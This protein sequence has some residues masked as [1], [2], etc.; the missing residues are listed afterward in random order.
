MFAWNLPH[1]FY[2][3]LIEKASRVLNLASCYA[4]NQPEKSASAAFL[5]STVGGK[6]IIHFFVE[7]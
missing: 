2:F 5:L 7:A 6:R 1:V 4:V 3:A